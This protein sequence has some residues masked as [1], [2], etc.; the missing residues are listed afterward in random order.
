MASPHLPMNNTIYEEL[1]RAP[2][3]LTHSD[4]FNEFACMAAANGWTV[5]PRKGNEIE[6]DSFM[7]R[8]SF[9]RSQVKQ[10][11]D[12][13]RDGKTRV[14]Q[15]MTVD[16][17]LESH[18]VAASL[19]DHVPAAFLLL[20]SIR[21]TEVYK[22][23]LTRMPLEVNEAIMALLNNDMVWDDFSNDIVDC[24]K[25]NLASTKY[26]LKG[27][28]MDYESKSYTT[29]LDFCR[30]RSEGVF[31]TKSQ[32]TK[33]RATIMLFVNAYI[34]LLHRF[35]TRRI[36]LQ[37]IHL[38]SQVMDPDVSCIPRGKIAAETLYYIAGYLAQAA[39]KE[40][41]RRTAI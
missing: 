1:H 9:S 18:D 33:L 32:T 16:E 17:N 8:H 22:N 24:L 28:R 35:L 6:L 31:I 11:F 10:K 41:T 20:K 3:F 15:E 38:P 21:S 30:I 26:E 36:Q 7:Q 2:Q 39:R 27:R 14:D 34:C 12:M 19:I 5:L 25:S 23:H 29:M 37:E 4:A 13:W 40:A